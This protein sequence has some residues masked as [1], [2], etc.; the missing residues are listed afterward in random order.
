M[1]AERYVERKNL[2]L[3]SKSE[4]KFIDKAFKSDW[5]ISKDGNLVKNEKY[6]GAKFKNAINTSTKEGQ[7]VEGWVNYTKYVFENFK[8]ALKQN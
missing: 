2:G 7:V 4:Q 6:N 8:Q 3:L 1:D 5:V